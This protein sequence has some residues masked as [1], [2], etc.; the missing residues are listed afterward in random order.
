[1]GEWERERLRIRANEL[2]KVNTYRQSKSLQAHLQEYLHSLGKKDIQLTEIDEAFGQGYK[3]H[4]VK[5]KNLGPAQANHCLIWLNRLLWL[6]VDMEILRC[7]PIENVEYEKKIQTR[8]RFV[9]R[10]DFKKLLS[11]PMADDRMEM[12]RH[13]FIFSSLT[14]LAYVDARGFYPHHIGKTADGRRYIRINRQKTKVE[15]FIPL[16][17]IAEQILGMYNTT[18]DEKPVFPLPSLNSAWSDIHEMGFAIGRTE[19]LS[20]HMAR[21]TFGTMLVSEG[22]CLESI[23][24]M[25]GHSSVKSTQ[26]Y[27]KITDDNISRDMDRKSVVPRRTYCITFPRIKCYDKLF[28]YPQGCL[29]ARHHQNDRGRHSDH[30]RQRRV[31]DGGR[32]CG[33][34][35]RAVRHR[36]PSDQAYI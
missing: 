2:N 30:A 35:F 11:T 32:D 18:D 16:H 27:A 3:V 6:G 1:M 28:D 23:A 24:K 10:E 14:G 26:V 36:V 20:A 34:V 29:R 15:S 22:I 17:P 8:H 13:W 19:N 5:G 21:H 12:F 4:L 9:N 33:H 31:D 7:N 25:M